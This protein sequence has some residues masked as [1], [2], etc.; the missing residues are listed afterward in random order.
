MRIAAQ[1][2]VGLDRTRRVDLRTS[3]RL[4][5]GGE[6]R[7]DQLIFRRREIVREPVGGANR[8]AAVAAHIPRETRRAARNSA[9]ACS[10]RSAP[11]G[12]RVAGIDETGRRVREHGALDVVAEVVEAEVVDGAIQDVLS[13]VRAPSE[14]PR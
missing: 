11:A 8:R 9:T 12:T 6:L 7:V 14:G 1:V 13:E 5:N 2:R 10:A 3:E 4:P